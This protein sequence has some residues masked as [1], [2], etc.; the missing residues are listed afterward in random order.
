[1]SGD[2]PSVV[3]ATARLLPGILMAG[4]LTVLFTLLCLQWSFARG[5]LSQDVTYDDSMY[6]FEAGKHLEV[7]YDRGLAAFVANEWKNPPHAPFSDLGAVVAFAIFGLHDWAPYVG[8]NAPVV[9]LLML[10]VNYLGR[11]LDLRARIVLMVF[12]LTIPLSV[13]TLCEYRPDFPGAIFT[14]AGVFLVGESALW[15]EGR[16]Q[17]GQWTLGGVFFGLALLTKSVFFVH[18][19]A[20]EIL[21]VAGGAC[22]LGWK[23]EDGTRWRSVPRGFAR[24]A[25]RVILPSLVLAA[26]YFL[27]NFRETFGYFYDFALGAHRHVSELKGGLA[28]SVHFYTFGYAGK[29]ILGGSFFVGLVLYTLCLGRIV[30]SKNKPELLFQL[31]LL[32]PAFVSLGAIILNR[33]ENQYFGVPA[34]TLLL[35][36]L[37]RAAVAAWPRSQGAN[38]TAAFVA[39]LCV[40]DLGLLDLSVV[41]PYSTPQIDYVVRR[42]RSIN[43]Q[44]LDDI[45]RE[46]GSRAAIPAEPPV[47][48]VTR[49]GFV[50]AQTF[51]WLALKAGRRL[52]FTDVWTDNRL[53]AFR[54]GLREATFVVA[55]EDGAAGVYDQNAAW[56]LRFE[57][58]RLLA[59]TPHLRLLSRYPT[60]PGGPGHRLFVNDEKMLARF[61]G[62][63]D[64]RAVEGFLPWEGPY[65]QWGLGRVRWAVGPQTRFAF[66]APAARAAVLAIS[67]RADQPVRASLHFRGQPVLQ[68]DLPSGS[69]FQA[70]TVPVDLQAGEN[71]F[72][73]TYE[74][75]LTQAPDGWQ[76]AF[77]FRQLEL[78]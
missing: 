54:E 41:W 40:L 27:V 61:G 68:I 58:E 2:S 63:G 20:L 76:R 35:F 28:A 72:V 36:A 3:P 7:F 64:F 11:S 59:E 37:L 73:L 25:V 53:E 47:T 9:L 15:R 44:I 4:L 77:L 70:F 49:G 52:D 22:L 46:F 12:T 65:P 31:F 45:W 75:A 14:A 39:A 78:R 13:E 60:S 71:E 19:L 18:T 42:D 51:R 38:R 23:A 8:V 10:F 5:R 29:L 55:P 33:R 66:T 24:I 62:F 48:F 32:L 69:G 67:V 34:D 30:R 43:Q 50:A 21:A 56:E 57:V 6:M 26:P 17:D 1:M 16:A 74:N